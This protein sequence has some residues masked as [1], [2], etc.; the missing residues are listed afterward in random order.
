M[1]D[2]KRALEERLSRAEQSLNVLQHP[3]RCVCRGGFHYCH[4]LD[5]INIILNSPPCPEHIIP[6]RFVLGFGPPIDPYISEEDRKFLS[7]VTSWTDLAADLLRSDRFLD[8]YEKIQNLDGKL[9][10]EDDETRIRLWH[11]LKSGDWEREP[12]P[13]DAGALGD[14]KTGSDST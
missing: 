3:S 6:F 14:K 1:T 12:L 8:A 7:P 5:I 9:P 11:W 10:K 2:R 4:P 13:L